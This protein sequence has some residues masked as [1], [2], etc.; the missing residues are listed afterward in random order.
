MKPAAPDPRAFT[1]VELLVVIAIIGV[2]MG[3]LIVSLRGSR[4]Q[5]K[6]IVCAS[7]LRALSVG[8]MVYAT[9][10]NGQLTPARLPEYAQGG[11]TNPL[12]HY[13][14]ST[15]LKYRPRWPVLMQAQ[16]GAP[17]LRRP[18][19]DRDRENYV[20]QVYRCPEVSDWNDERNS[21][22]GYNYQ[23]LGNH[24]HLANESYRKL[25]V[26]LSRILRTA[27]TVSMADSNGSAASVPEGAR[28]P[29]DNNGNNVDGRGNY[30]WVI[31]PPRLA[32]GSSRAGGP[33]SPRSGPDPRHRAR[34]NAA[35]VDG[36]VTAMT[37]KELGYGVLPDG[38]VL[39]NGQ[40]ANNRLF[41]GSGED[42]DP[43]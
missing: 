12:N 17:A 14:V 27:E 31:D 30:G 8:W 39:D 13:Q 11:F 28:L 6:S 22:F 18:Q 34:S 24:R 5:A 2:L 9:E 21:A 20:D 40:G 15:G 10:H 32:P 35:F 7:R 19:T 42:E 3:L 38:R 26:L 36:H 41:S 23:F 37:L 25:P 33:G 4:D 29:Y 1:L 43:P 16:V